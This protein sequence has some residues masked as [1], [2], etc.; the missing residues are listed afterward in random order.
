MS[1]T[2]II[3]DVIVGAPSTSGG[4][5]GR[6][7]QSSID[8]LPDQSEGIKQKHGIITQVHETKPLVKILSESSEVIV[9]TGW[10]PLA[11]SVSEIAERFGTIREGM[12]VLVSMTGF[13]NSGATATIV[14]VEG[15]KFGD[16]TKIENEIKTSA[17][18]IYSPGIGIG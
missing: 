4:E 8:S 9:G 6:Q 16:E 17:F 7:T 5:K 1:S 13:G 15:E 11:H 12:K 10:I 2:G 3:S 18:E 14:G